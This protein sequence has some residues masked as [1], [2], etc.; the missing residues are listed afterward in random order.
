MTLRDVWGDASILLKGVQSAE[1]ARAALEWG[2]DGVIV[3][4]VSVRVIYGRRF[5]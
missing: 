5:C 3:S 4:N 2:L 1:D